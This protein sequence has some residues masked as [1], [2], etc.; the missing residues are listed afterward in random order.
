MFKDNIWDG[1]LAD[2]QLISKYN[3]DIRFLLCVIDL[4]STYS[5]VVPLK[6]KKGVTIVNS[7]QSILNYLTGA[8]YKIWVDQGST[9]YYKSLKKL[10]DDNDIKMYSP[11]NEGK[12]DVAER[13]I[14]T[15]KH[16]I[17]KCMTAVSKNVYFNVLD[18][19]V[20]KYN[21]TFHKTI[22][23][24]PIDVKSDSHAEYNVDSNVEDAKFK[25][26][27]RVRISKYKNIF[28]IGYAPN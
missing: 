13:F 7:F 18:G 6:D 25:I 14:R 17:Y 5:W 22:K 2:M 9:F 24:K 11:L 26:G 28:A 27:H 20:D 8:P 12:S 10:L 4:F 1:D 16:K 15:L 23:M 21:N 3:K 19:I